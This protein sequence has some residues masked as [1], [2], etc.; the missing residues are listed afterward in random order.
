MFDR[1]VVGGSG[2]KQKLPVTIKLR[3]GSVCSVMLL[4]PPALKL[5]DV[6][7]RAEPF[8]EVEMEDGSIL[9]LAKARIEEAAAVSTPRAAQLGHLAA[10]FDPHALLGVPRGAAPETIRARYLECVKQ[11]HPDR[12]AG[13]GLPAEVEGY[14]ATMLQRINAAYQFLAPRERVA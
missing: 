1:N 6:L 13:L 5:I 8:V 10:D 3:D 11:Y 2:A 12:F 14:A 4:A 7:N 9:I